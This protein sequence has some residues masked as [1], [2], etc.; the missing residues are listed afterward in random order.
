MAR[1]PLAHGRLTYAAETYQSN[2]IGPNN[3]PKM[4]NRY[5]TLGRVTAWPSE[6]GSPMPQI[7]IDLDSVPVG[8]QASTKLFIFW[9]SANQQQGYEPQPQSFGS[10]GNA[11]QQQQMPQQQQPMHP[12]NRAP[13]S[14]PN[15]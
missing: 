9:D 2:E 6:D 14:Y 12:Q 11:P 4:K 8:I 10:W 7:N 15:K 13:Q 5:A 1:Q 3:Q